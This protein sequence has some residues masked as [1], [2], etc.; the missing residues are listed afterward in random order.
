MRLLELSANKSSFRTV[1]FKR[2]G[3]SLVV[4]EQKSAASSQTETYNGVGKSLM[5]ELIHFCLGSNKNGAFEKHLGGWVFTLSVEV[6][7]NVHRISRRADKPEE[8]HL[9]EKTVTL[10]HLK[11]SLREWCFDEELDSPLSFRSLISRF[12]RSGRASY[13]EFSYA[14]QG[15]SKK[16]YQAMLGSAFLL[17]L[18]LELARDK[19]R[20]RVRQKKLSDT[21]KQLE[22]DPLFSKLLAEDTIEIELTALREEADRLRSDLD[23]FQVADD[24]HDIE[25]EANRIRRRLTLLR[26]ESIKLSEAI[27]QVDR[28]LKA[29]PDLPTDRVFRMYQE[30][31]T[32]L[33]D[34]VRRRIE[35]VVE[36]Q[37]ELQEKRILRLTRERQAIDRQHTS[38]LGE[39]GEVSAELDRKLGYLSDHRALDEYVAVSSKLGEVLQQVAKLEESTKLRASVD[40]ERRR[41]ERDLA[42]GSIRTEKYLE[43]ASALVGQA[44]AM[45]RSFA[46]ELYGNRPSGLS[47]SSD[48]GE[49]QLR[50]RID[51]HISSDAAEGINEVKIFCYDMTL[52]ALRRSHKIEFLV[53]DSTLFGPVDPR[54]RIQIFR[55]ADKV[56]KDLDMQYIA[57]LNLHDITSIRGQVEMADD[58]LERLIGSDNIVLT[59]TDESEKARL[60]GINVEMDYTK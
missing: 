10:L 39:I 26:R 12:I 42:D 38:G 14:N 58:E 4:A 23:A 7:G 30:A 46:K 52:L 44:M 27:V 13:N 48:D 9:D 47:I 56:C 45:F 36:F 29:T 51:A 5:L 22:K 8:I 43:S 33:P 28:S 21:M 1:R 17:G 40:K 50:Y 2:A 20:L 55:I 16:P 53:H 19:Y 59:L 31:S 3:L 35:D 34:L 15:D 18:D 60:L 41:I 24:Y 25:K 54:Q 11:D 32:A 49:N 6:S 37:R 57:T